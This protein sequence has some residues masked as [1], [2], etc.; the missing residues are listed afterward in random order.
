MQGLHRDLKKKQHLPLMGNMK[1]ASA[2]KD[3]VKSIRKC[4]DNI[5]I[6]K[7]SAGVAILQMIFLTDGLH[8]TSS[9]HAFTHTQTCTDFL[10]CLSFPDNLI[11][12]NILS[13]LCRWSQE[14]RG[15][16]GLCTQKVST[17]KRSKDLFTQIKSGSESEKDQ[18]I[19]G[20]H[21]SNFSLS[22]SLGVNG[23]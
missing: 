9:I 11:Q 6:L 3:S 14:A 1:S 23:P 10:L 15:L 12:P 5:S 19:N 13:I 22:L 16:G 21:Q 4:D 8:N 17:A 20:K 2:S 7:T 18:R